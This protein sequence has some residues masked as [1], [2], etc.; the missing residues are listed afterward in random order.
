M[1]SYT[2]II[3]LLKW[4]WIGKYRKGVHAI[5]SFSFFRWWFLDRLV[6]IWEV[7]IGSLLLDTP[8]I[9]GIYVLL[10]A[11][12]SPS[13]RIK[14][15]IREFDLFSAASD[16]TVA[17][18]VFCHLVDARGLVLDEISVDK[19]TALEGWSVAYPGENPSHDAE[20]SSAGSG[21]HCYT[22]TAEKTPFSVSVQR[23]LAPIVTLV[24][25]LAFASFGN[26][27]TSFLISTEVISGAG[28]LFVIFISTNIFLIFAAAIL[29]RLELCDFIADYIAGMSFGF[30]NHWMHMTQL[31]NLIHAYFFGTRVSIYAQLNNPF[32]VAPSKGRY[33]TVE[34]GA[35][36]S[37]AWIGASK[38]TPTII[39]KFATIGARSRIGKGVTIEEG[40]VISTLAIVPDNS[41]V[42]LNSSYFSSSF[43]TKASPN[44]IEYKK[45]NI[46]LFLGKQLLA[47]F[48]FQAIPTIFI[49]AAAIFAVSYPALML[50]F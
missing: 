16:S 44:E 48:I 34:E 37:F 33:L 45:P 21:S 12:I 18:M 13:A 17:G 24:L 27:W 19:D 9:N 36:V 3:I 32:F 20:K 25:V 5:W 31:V 14:T 8:Y 6:N 10:G 38:E 41:I 30:L 2:S 39:R 7:F 43:S 35:T 1:G 22:Q 4:L 46:C 15:F 28:R 26:F 23:W 50:D 29:V 49:F 42:P 40:A 11:R 47:K